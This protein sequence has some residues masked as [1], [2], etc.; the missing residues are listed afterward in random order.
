MKN[1]IFCLLLLF[2]IHEAKAQKP[3]L[4]LDTYKT[5]PE[6]RNGGISNDGKFAFYQMHNVPVGRNTYIIR[7]TKGN[8]KREILADDQPIFTWDS[9]F[10][11]G[12]SFDDSLYILDLYKGNIKRISKISSFRLFKLDSDSWLS[13]IQNN[14]DLIIQSLDGKT[15]HFYTN[16]LDFEIN[17]KGNS[18]IVKRLISSDGHKKEMVYLVD[19]ISN[20]E[21]LIFEGEGSGS[22][23][24]DDE[25]KQ[26][27]F[28]V[29]KV[30]F[31]E[32]WYYKVG[33]NR[34]VLKA[35]D[36]LL[37]SKAEFTI[38][39]GAYWGFSK[40]GK[41]IFFSSKEKASGNVKSANDLE[42]WSYKDNFLKS[43]YYGKNIYGL[44][45]IEPLEYLT[46]LHV[47]EDKVEQLLHGRQQILGGSLKHETDSVF[48]VTSLFEGGNGE[49]NSNSK[50]SYYI[51]HT[52][53]GELKPIELDLHEGL[54]EIALSPSG[55][56][57][58]YF[59]IRTKSY[60]SYIVSTGEKKNLTKNIKENWI[61]YFLQDYPQP[62]GMIIGIS[63]WMEN[64]AAILVN[65]TFD[66]WSLDP[67]NGKP[68]INLTQAQGANKHIVFY[69][70]V[71]D[72]KIK[73][74]SRDI[75]LVSA[76]NLRSKDYGFYEI[77]ILSYKLKKLYMGPVFSGHIEN[78]Y[79]QLDDD[80]LIK[81]SNSKNYMIRLERVNK[82]PNYFITSDFVSYSAI[83]SLQPQLQFNWMTSELHEYK[84][85][86]GN[87]YQGI[88]YKPEDFDPN[89]S[90]PVAFNYYTEK[91][92]LLNSFPKT[93][94]T[95]ADFT[96]SLLVSN[97]YLV[98][99]PDIHAKNKH[100]G[101]G[102]VLS[103]VA[104]ANHLIT[105]P[106][107]KSNKM[108]IAGS[109]FGGFETNYIVTHTNR[110]AAAISG[111]GVS[112]MISFASGIWGGGSSQQSFVQNT[113]LKM[114]STLSED[115]DTYIRN[116][117]ILDAGKVQTP[118]LLMHN[119][120]DPQV[121]FIQSRSFF[122]VLR[123]LQKKVWWL[124]YNTEGHGILKRE[125]LLDYHK[126]VFEFLDHYL[127][128]KP[129]PD[130]MKDHI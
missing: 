118:L 129:E 14:S 65:G 68:P 79:T 103:L 63:G 4:T 37:D 49:W 77:N 92:N 48:L 125:N 61:N 38:D 44:S 112:D 6:V 75:I 2:Y 18:F 122:I 94:L 17:P 41:M 120:K 9:R 35:K 123:N 22:F 55:K 113:A 130:W 13:Y 7:S 117:P 101:D 47:G 76:F 116:S 60:F 42:I 57:V 73:M 89:K 11:I 58:A 30:D 36:Q 27:A 20:K 34:S 86:L 100:S 71:R 43:F 99:L 40:N 107:V 87:A 23:T 104:A 119:T 33:S 21:T 28:I 108:A 66:L 56:Y 128:E 98:F 96:V 62:D 109:S 64:D 59:D 114:Q 127:K 31:N 53:S 72:S 54:P 10:L 12:K 69:P 110:F 84:D 124:N 32:L 95:A 46:V 45:N 88:L 85:S 24:F 126:K 90:Y 80:D 5:W 82:A 115:N 83:S 70:V 105:Y 26:I 93:R 106:W 51:C 102:A 97:G 67:L 121:P 111:A 3:P 39:P 78:V 52:N 50:I 81:S 91:S 29:K 74:L 15:K 19:L 1:Y 16:T 8:F 25:G